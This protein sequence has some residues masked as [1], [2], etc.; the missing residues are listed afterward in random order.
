M[1][2]NYNVGYV[3]GWS[4]TNSV[5]AE[6]WWK[7]QGR[8]WTWAHVYYPAP[9]RVG[10]FADSTSTRAEAGATFWGVMNMSDNVAEM[11]ISAYNAVGRAFVGTHGCGQLNPN[12]AATHKDW[13]MSTDAKYYICRGMMFNITTGSVSATQ[14]KP[15]W[16]N[17]QWW[18]TTGAPAAN[19]TNA[20]GRVTSNEI[21]W[22]V[23]NMNRWEYWA[24]MISS[25][26]MFANT[27]APGNRNIT[28]NGTQA[29]GAP[30]RGIRCVRTY[31]AEK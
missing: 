9:L 14:P 27:I 16:W 21:N 24:G 23:G 19:A 28:T 25:R 22:N 13:H 3:R 15:G 18:Q 5:S 7:D 26:H 2:P 11:C 4:T 20:A 12:G 6:P 30:M 10:I 29:N 31:K 1:G 8:T 17:C